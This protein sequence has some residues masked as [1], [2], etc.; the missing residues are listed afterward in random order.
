MS[1]R[2]NRESPAYV[3]P[4][5]SEGL[6]VGRDSK[7]GKEL[8]LHLGA[9]VPCHPMSSLARLVWVIYVNVS[10]SF[11]CSWLL[12]KR[13]KVRVSRR[14]TRVPS[15]RPLRQIDGLDQPQP[16]CL[17]DAEKSYVVVLL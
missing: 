8:L 6:A 10:C 16:G 2:L 13:E 14:P 11:P 4:I 1:F 15:A 12:H 3:I 5:E 9:G 17:S 7:S